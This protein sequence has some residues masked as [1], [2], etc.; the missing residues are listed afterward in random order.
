MNSKTTPHFFLKKIFIRKIENSL[1][2]IYYHCTGKRG[3]NCKKYW[4]QEEELD[5]AFLEL[6]AKLTNPEGGLKN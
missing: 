5:E 3:G 2:N 6:P 4:I 1:S